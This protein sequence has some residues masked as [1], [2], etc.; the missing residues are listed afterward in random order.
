LAE[1]LPRA[2]IDVM[3]IFALGAFVGLRLAGILRLDWTAVDHEGGY[4]EFTAVKSNAFQ[5][6]LLKFNAVPYLGS[7]TVRLQEVEVQCR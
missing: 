5:Q 7:S 6:K 1:F 2:G 3:P 4:I